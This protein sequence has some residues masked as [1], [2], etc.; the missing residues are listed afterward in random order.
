MGAYD[1]LRIYTSYDLVTPSCLIPEG[2]EYQSPEPCVTVTPDSDTDLLGQ[3]V[4]TSSNQGLG[5]IPVLLIMA[6]NVVY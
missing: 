5:V 6:W 2:T 1:I 3:S 4:L